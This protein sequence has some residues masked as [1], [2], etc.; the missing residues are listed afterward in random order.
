MTKLNRKHLV[1]M[2]T[3]GAIAL[4]LSA[5]PM[6]LGSVGSP[7]DLKVAKAGNPGSS[8]PGASGPGVGDGNGGGGGGGG[9]SGN[10]GQP[11]REGNSGS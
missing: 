1:L 5:A 11:G 9:K 2:A 6:Q 10:K 8:G 3:T 4:A 7:L